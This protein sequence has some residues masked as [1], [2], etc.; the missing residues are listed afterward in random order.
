[1]TENPSSV[2]LSQRRRAK[3]ILI[4]GIAS[5]SWAAWSV[6]YMGFGLWQL[7]LQV[8]NVSLLL[9]FP[10]CL[11]LALTTI[12]IAWKHLRPIPTRAADKTSQ[13]L[14]GAGAIL[15]TV[16]ILLLPIGFSALSL[17]D[18]MTPQDAMTNDISNLWAEVYQYRFRPKDMGGGGGSYV[19]FIIRQKMHTNADARYMVSVIHRDTLKITGASLDGKGS[20]VAYMDSSGRLFKWEYGGEFKEESK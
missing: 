1:M 2:Q 6:I 18:Y 13:R 14:A 16:S 5:Y 20:V 9:V 3:L 11:A 8:L 17:P 7:H 19:G 12:V 15:G 4:L 10:V